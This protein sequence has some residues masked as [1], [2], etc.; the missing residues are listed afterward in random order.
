MAREFN[1]GFVEYGEIVFR[2]RATLFKS[3]AVEIRR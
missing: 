1:R 2:D 3:G